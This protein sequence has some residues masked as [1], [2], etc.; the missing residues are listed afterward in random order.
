MP[1]LAP[2]MVTYL[3]LLAGRSSVEGET[4]ISNQIACISA[5]NSLEAEPVLR[6][7]VKGKFLEPCLGLRIRLWR[8]VELHAYRVAIDAM[9]AGKVSRGDLPEKE[10]RSGQ[11][12]THHHA[13]RNR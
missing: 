9:E 7:A 12:L 3:W 8:G 13:C 5:E 1:E 4:A 6:V 11:D 2:E 10:A